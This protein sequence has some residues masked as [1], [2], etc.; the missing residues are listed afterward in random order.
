M[1]SSQTG[2]R[3]SAVSFSYSS[4]CMSHVTKCQ[5]IMMFLNP[6]EGTSSKFD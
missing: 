6:V 2:I 1:L 3:G 4:G 5:V